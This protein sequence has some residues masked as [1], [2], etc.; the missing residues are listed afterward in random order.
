MGNAIARG[1]GDAFHRPDTD[2]YHPGRAF[3]AGA[4][5]LILLPGPRHNYE[6]STGQAL[7]GEDS[8][9]G[10]ALDNHEGL[11]RGPNIV[12]N[13]NFSDGS[14]GWNTGGAAT[15]SDGV[16]NFAA[17][18]DTIR[19]T[20][21]VPV[22][23]YELLF[24]VKNYVKGGINAR[25]GDFVYSSVS[26]DGDGDYRAILKSAGASDITIKAVS[27]GASFSVD[28]VSVRKLPGHHPTQATT[29]FKPRL[30][31]TVGGVWYFSGDGSDD[32]IINTDGPILTQPYAISFVARRVGTGDQQFLYSGQ[33]PD[34]SI[35][36]A[37]SAVAI[38]AGTLLSG[39]DITQNEF[40][41]ITAVFNGANSELYQNG[42]LAAS[43]NAGTNDMTGI[44]LFAKYDGTLAGEVDIAPVVAMNFE[45]SV[46]QRTNNERW[47]ANITGVSL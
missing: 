23:F 18:S 5:G 34:V 10:M 45:P 42:V 38:N 24:E 11:K 37:S 26:I 39:D 43:G 12:T 1:V 8:V 20:P 28:N 15:I 32:Y 6:E 30:Q 47:L 13:G 33:S 2:R 44:S 27:S 29:G 25:V 17:A 21:S 22:G 46:T 35:E 36:Y 3:I 41:V 40:V 4:D 16:A 31:R 9:V 19:Q 14:T 7:A